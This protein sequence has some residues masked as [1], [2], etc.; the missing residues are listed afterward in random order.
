MVGVLGDRA[1]LVVIQ[2][3]RA[4]GKIAVQHEVLEQLKKFYLHSNWQFRQEVV[5]TLKKLL[6]REILRPQDVAAD[7]DQI[8]ASSPYFIP[9]FPLKDRLQELAEL[10]RPSNS[11]A[12]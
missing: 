6:E 8:L 9:E 4:L 11:G 12:S 7:L 3:I 10:V 1:S 2:V 5:S